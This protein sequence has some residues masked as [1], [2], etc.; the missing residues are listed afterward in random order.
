MGKGGSRY[1][2]GRPGYRAKAEHLQR[3]DIRQW[4]QRGYLRAGLHFSWS[5]TRG[6]EPT[7]SIG[8]QVF[9]P[10]SLRL[11]YSIVGNDDQRHDA[12]QSIGIDRTQCNYGGARPWFVCPVCHRRA[13]LLYLRAGRFACRQC[14]RVA[15]ASQSCD[16]LDRMWRKQAKIE[17]RLGDNWKRPKGMRRHTHERLIDALVD[18][19]D[20]R[21]QAFRVMAARLFGDGAMREILG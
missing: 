7:G 1:G 6:G 14:Q 19:E 4:Q 20:L 13:G 2:A 11:Q 17:A 8:V 3:V 10:D 12:S 16:A 18:C 15:Y 9:G 5:W 21:D